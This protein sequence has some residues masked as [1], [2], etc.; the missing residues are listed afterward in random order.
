MARALAFV[1]SIFFVVAATGCGSGEP[2]QQ[3][4]GVVTGA[5]VSVVLA[6]T[7]G[8]LG[9]GTPQGAACDPSVWTYTVTLANHDVGWDRCQVTGAWDNPT[10]YVLDQGKIQVA[11]GS[12]AAIQSALDGLQFSSGTSCG[13]DAPSRDLTVTNASG[14]VQ[15]GDDFY[16]CTMTFPRY[17]TFDSLNDLQKTLLNVP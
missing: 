6:S 14:S 13:E 5:T 15:Y 11:A 16:A 9:P 4:N 8:G 17:V 10:D 2:L 7:G 12:W 1:L 3:Q